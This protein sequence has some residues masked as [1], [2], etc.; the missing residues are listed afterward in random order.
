MPSLRMP[1]RAFLVMLLWAVFTAFPA[2]AQNNGV[3]LNVQG[4]SLES[5][6]GKIEHQTDYRFFYSRDVIDVSVPVSLHVDNL[7]L[8]RALDKLFAGRGIA[9]VI[10]KKQIVLSAAEPAP[11]RPSV[12]VRGNV[13]DSSGEPL[14]GVSVSAAGAPERPT[15]DINGDYE[16]RVPAVAALNFTFVGCAPVIKNVR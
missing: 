8:P 14:I 6:L 5:V 16:I 12:V 15:T 4:A 13:R 7:P 3:T 9:Y 10:D 11:E 2:E 1:G